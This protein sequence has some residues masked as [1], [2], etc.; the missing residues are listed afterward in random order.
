MVLILP[1][2]TSVIFGINRLAVR[3]NVRTKTTFP[4][5]LQDGQFAS[6]T[7]HINEGMDCSYCFGKEFPGEFVIYFKR[8]DLKEV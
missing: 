4:L 1:E 8:L 3:S 5:L 6:S 2:N 7:N